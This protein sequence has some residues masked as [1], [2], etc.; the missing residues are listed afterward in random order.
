MRPSKHQVRRAFGKAAHTYDEAAEVQRHTCEALAQSLP[1]GLTPARI[2]DAGCGTAYGLQLLAAKFPTAFGIGVDLAEA[3]LRQSRPIPG[4][5][6][7]LEALPVRSKTID[8]YWSSLTVQWCDLSAVLHEAARVLRPGG[9]LAITTLGPD[10]FW[11]L[12]NAFAASDRYQHTLGFIPAEA[13]P[14]RAAVEGF[15]QITLQRERL[16]THH[17]D[18]RSLLKSVKA[19]GANQIGPGRRTGLMTR[20]A[21]EKAEAT[22]ETLRT[23][24]GL[25]LT[26]DLI[27]LTAGK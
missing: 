23:S 1:A 26:Y 21:L 11:E 19:I 9:T 13:I 25:P 18:L 16:L 7:D 3:M 2:L 5:V 20:S 22:Y 24:E 15:A 14:A 4:A 17:A 10:T 6:G 12:R 27:Y 8:L